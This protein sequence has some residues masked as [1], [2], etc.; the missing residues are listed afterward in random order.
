MSLF[1][2]L[3]TFLLEKFPLLWHTK[4][5]YACLVS[6]LIS[7]LYYFW[8]YAFTGEYTINRF[9]SDDYFYKSNALLC[10]IIINTIFVIAWTLSFFRKSAVKN[11]YPLQRFYFTRLFCSFLIIFWSLTWP[12]TSF[13]HGVHAKIRKLAPLEELEAHIE[14]INFADAFLFENDYS[15]GVYNRVH[16]PNVEQIN[17]DY[18]ESQWNNM[19]TILCTDSILR[20]DP[21]NAKGVPILTNSK[22]RPVEIGITTYDPGRH[23]ENND[24]VE[25]KLVQ[26]IVTRTVKT[27]APCAEDDV[28]HYVVGAKKLEQLCPN[29]LYDLRNFSRQEISPNYFNYPVYQNILHEYASG[30]NNYRIY[31]D[32]Y[33]EDRKSSAK[34]NRSFNAFLSKSSG[35]DLIQLLGKYE[36]LLTRHGIAHAFDQQ[37]IVA[38]VLKR[39]HRMTF[40][41]LVAKSYIDSQLANENLMRYGNLEKYE[42][43]R[44]ESEEYMQP[45]YF[46][47]TGQLDHLFSNSYDA[48]N[49]ATN[50]V[51]IIVSM[52]F[53]LGC[54]FV[55]FL[56][57]IGNPVNLI[58]AASAGG[59]LVI[60]NVLFFL[61]FLQYRGSDFNVY[62]NME[63]RV[64]SQLLIFSAILYSLLYL[65]YSM[66]NGSKRVLLITFN[67]CFMLTP[68]LPFFAMLFLESL[69]RT[70]YS[71]AC[72]GLTFRHTLFRYWAED[73]MVIWF[74]AF[75]AILLFTH[76][77]KRVL[78]KPE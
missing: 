47:E 22:G 25:G 1:K 67:L 53:A 78:A 28:S 46:V 76:F 26:F 69:L 51:F 23:P 54:A 56:F 30:R 75:G 10:L 50:W 52:Y 61:L 19:Y 16:H 77:I 32:E 9:S 48:H 36:Q 38:Y 5:L 73:P 17:Y 42:Q 45:L 7:L 34:A 4:L 37:A 21:A 63:L 14:T 33:E 58:I 31:Y 55:F 2:K 64:H 18:N 71:D 13:N 66:R 68:L 35:E 15:Y 3:D 49:P 57:A 20:R 41:P 8:G 65:F 72:T 44:R 62:Q 29:G 39:Q 24:T 70:T 6:A 12:A 43:V 60:L 74:S 27:P 40:K 59:I 11:L